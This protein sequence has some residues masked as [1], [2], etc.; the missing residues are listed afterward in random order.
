MKQ[1]NFPSKASA[2]GFYTNAGLKVYLSIDF[3]AVVLKTDDEESTLK[4]VDL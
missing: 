2:S 4:F 3:K 1:I